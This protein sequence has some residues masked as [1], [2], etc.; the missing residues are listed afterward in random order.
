VEHLLD[1]LGAASVQLSE[2]LMDRVEALIN[3]RT[4]VGNRYNAQG[5]GEVDTET[6][7]GSAG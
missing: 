5:S 6:F 4:V 7:G 1:D 3:E 2:P